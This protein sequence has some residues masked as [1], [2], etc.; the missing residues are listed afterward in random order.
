MPLIG[1]IFYKTPP[2]QKLHRF[3]LEYP[4]AGRTTADYDDLPHWHASSRRQA[5]DV[6]LMCE[7]ELGL[8][9]GETKVR[10]ST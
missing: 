7:V 3:K 1:S 6:I 8:P 4:D 2:Y 9:G 10:M 5:T